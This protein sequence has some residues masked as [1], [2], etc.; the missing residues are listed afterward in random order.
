VWN[1]EHERIA[2]HRLRVPADLP[3]EFRRVADD[4]EGNRL[5]AAQNE[6]LRTAQQYIGTQSET[7]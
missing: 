1:A 7:T 5:N 3:A 4:D 6:F 2:H